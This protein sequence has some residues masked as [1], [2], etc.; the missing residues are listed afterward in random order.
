MVITEWIG[1]GRVATSVSRPPSLLQSPSRNL[2]FM[3]TMME[4]GVEFVAVDNPHASKLTLHISADV[5]ER[6]G[7][8]DF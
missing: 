6:E 1:F 5:A 8:G 3:A 7:G 2:A 4:S